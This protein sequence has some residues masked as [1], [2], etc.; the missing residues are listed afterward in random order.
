MLCQ[1]LKNNQFY[2]IK[3]LNKENLIK[4]DQI[5]H[6]VTERNLLT[7]IDHVFL[8]KLIYAF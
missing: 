4:S 6:T 2:A 7:L 8:V 1:H 3:T 5:V